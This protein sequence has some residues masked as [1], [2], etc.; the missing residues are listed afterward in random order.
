MDIGVGRWFVGVG[1]ACQVQVLT[2]ANAAVE[3]LAV[4]GLERVE[5]RLHKHVE[6]REPVRFGT[7]AFLV[8][9]LPIRRNRGDHHRHAVG[10]QHAGHIARALSLKEPVGPGVVEVAGQRVPED[11]AVEQL[12]PHGRL[13]RVNQRLRNSGLSAGG[14][15]CE[16]ENEPRGLAGG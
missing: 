1:D 7:Y 16:T 8:T 9:G 2:L 10:G 14:K 6:K 5:L 13:Q 12:D 15:A 3:P 4:P 11:V